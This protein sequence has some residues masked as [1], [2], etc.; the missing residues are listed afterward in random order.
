L[1]ITKDKDELYTEDTYY[2]YRYGGEAPNQPNTLFFSDRAIYRPG[3]KFYFKG[4]AIEFN[5]K[6]IPSI[7]ANRDVDITLY[8]ANGKEVSKKNFTSNAYGTFAGQFDLPQ[9]GLTGQMY[10]TSSHGNSRYY[11]QVEEYKRPK[12]EVTFDTLKETVRLDETVHVKAISKDYAGSPVGGAKVG[13][14]VERVSYL[15]WW[16]G[17]YRKFAP[18]PDDRQVL[19]VGQGVT[20]ED[21][22]LP[23]S[24]VAKSKPGS[25]ANLMYHFEVT[26]MVTDITGETHEATKTLTLNKQGYEVNIK[27]GNSIPITDF[28]EIEIIATNSDG[29][30]VNVS[31]TVEIAQ[32]TGP[33]KNKRD[34]LWAAPDVFTIS[35][36]DY[37][38]RFPNYF[39]PGKEDKS[40]WPVQSVVGSKTFNIN[41]SDTVELASVIRQSGYYRLTWKWKDPSGKELVITQNVMTY[42]PGQSLPA[43]EVIQVNWN[44]K[45]MNLVNLSKLICLPG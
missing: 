21:G 2:T 39:I 33:G 15:P 7:V 30:K 3:Q 31:G 27:L 20:N 37:A 40:T 16:Y 22:S 35:E 9:G 6:G 13:Y 24:F 28:K 45:P 44:N 11:F 8:D 18:T 32:L 26:V 5:S 42:A 4:Y 23:I 29:A 19:A 17:Y 41:G 14:R 34:R 36:T 10:V 25:D 38:G 1:R 43:G 12:F